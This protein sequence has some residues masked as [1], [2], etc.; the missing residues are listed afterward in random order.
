[1]RGNAG[2]WAAGRFLF[3][4]SVAI[5]M[6]AWA[7][8]GFLGGGAVFGCAARAVCAGGRD[9]RAGCGAERALAGGICGGIRGAALAV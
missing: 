3:A 2:L 5:L 1:M 6:P 4:G 9:A 8:V 7:A